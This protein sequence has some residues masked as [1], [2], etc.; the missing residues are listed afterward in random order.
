MNPKVLLNGVKELLNQSLAKELRDQGQF[1]GFALNRSM[2]ASVVMD[3]SDQ[4][5]L[6]G[7]ALNYTQ[8]LEEGKKGIDI[9]NMKAHITGLIKYFSLRGLSQSQAVL[10]AARTARRQ[11][12]EGLP[13]EASKRFSKT[14]ERKHFMTRVL[15]E[16]Q[17][18]VDHL[19]D[20]GMDSIFDSHFLTQKNEII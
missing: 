5:Q 20:S 19:M 14:G 17:Q 2:G 8:D 1:I 6:I 16:N 12:I 4:G 13:G 7:V 10:A 3:K 9:G 15:N 11:R 18:K